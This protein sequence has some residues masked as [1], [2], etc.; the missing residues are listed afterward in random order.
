MPC[1]TRCEHETPPPTRVSPRS[2]SP[3]VRGT[4]WKTKRSTRFSTSTS[5]STSITSSPRSGA[6]QWH[7][8]RAPGEHRQQDDDQRANQPRNRRCR[9]VVVPS[10]DRNPSA[11][12]LAAPR[13]PRGHSPFRPSSSAR[14]T[15][16]TFSVRGANRYASWSK[17][18]SVR[19]CN[20]T[21]TW[22]SP[23]K[24]P[25]S[26]SPMSF[27]TKQAWRTTDGAD[28]RDRIDRMFQ[29]MAP[30]L[31]D[32]I[33]SVVGQGDPALGAAWT[34][35]VRTQ[36]REKGAPSDKTYNPLDPQVQF[37][38]LTESNITNGFKPG[39]YPFEQDT[40]ASAGSLRHRAARGPQHVG[41]QRH[42][43]RRRRLPRVGHR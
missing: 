22:D 6:T 34:K 9:P 42:L 40:R 4:G 21:S 13:R 31:D 11:D 10:G 18:R 32:F 41:A 28:N 36:G 19:Q 12:R 25:H 14:T 26:S 3:E 20:E 2:S 43:Q 7:R 37:R 27:P 33:A 5:P 39:W 23:R 8:C 16:K 29:M 1:C 35:L 30:P 38:I 17:M 24:I 15:S